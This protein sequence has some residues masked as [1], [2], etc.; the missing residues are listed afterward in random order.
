MASADLTPAFCLCGGVSALCRACAI[1]MGWGW[2]VRLC[3]NMASLPIL[4]ALRE[5]RAGSGLG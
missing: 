5:I 3:G 4:K 1:R 2:K